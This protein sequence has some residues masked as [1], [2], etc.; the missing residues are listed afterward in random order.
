MEP[1]NNECRRILRAV[2]AGLLQVNGSK[3]YLIVGEEERPNPRARKKL[4]RLGLIAAGDEP[5]SWSITVA[6][7]NYLLNWDDVTDEAVAA[8]RDT[9]LYMPNFFGRVNEE[10]LRAILSAARPHMRG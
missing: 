9:T 4:A 8:A 10:D 3:R 5:Y 7:N 2:A 6:G 1:L